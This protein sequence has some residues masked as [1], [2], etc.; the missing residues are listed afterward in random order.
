MRAGAARPPAAASPAPSTNA[1][2]T[3]TSNPGRCPGETFA[4]MGLP[5]FAPLT[6]TSPPRA[7]GEQWSL[8][9]MQ[10]SLQYSLGGCL[11]LCAVALLLLPLAPFA[12]SQAADAP[13]TEPAAHKNYTEMIPDTKVGFDMVAIPGGTFVMGS[14]A[15]EKGRN[16][17]EGPQH[18]VQIRPF[19][20]GKCE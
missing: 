9:E 16:P 18:P 13:K 11:L 17:D 15:G 10:R 8:P 3:T 7:R 1:A 4:C 14:P 20:M 2:V 12:A 19:W 6:P 5:S